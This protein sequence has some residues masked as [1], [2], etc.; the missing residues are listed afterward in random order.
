MILHHVQQQINKGAIE[1]KGK[2]LI[3]NLCIIIYIIIQGKIDQSRLKISFFG[4]AKA[5]NQDWIRRMIMFSYLDP[6]Q[7]NCILPMIANHDRS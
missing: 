5:E 2:Q 7:Q 6:C 3:I 1:I 4:Q